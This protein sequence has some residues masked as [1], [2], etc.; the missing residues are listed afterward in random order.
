[1][2]IGFYID[3][4]NLRGVAN[5]TYLYALNNEKILKNKSIIFYNKKNFRNKNKV[6]KKFK[7]KF[8]CI[9]VS[10]FKEIELFKEK[11]DLNFLYTQKSGNKD[12]WISKKIRTIVHAAYPQTLNE[13]HG[14]NFAYVSEW[15]S[16]K[17]SNRKIPFVPYIT[18]S[19]K[20]KSNLRNKL[21][22]KKEYLVFG[23]HGGDSSFD[24]K[25]VQTAVANVAHNRKDIFFLFLNINKF[26][27]HPQVIFLKGTTDEDYKKRFI[28][29]CDAMIY[30]RS[31]GE[32]FGMACAEF[33]V[34]NKDIL[35]YKFNRHRCHKYNSE[36]S[37]YFE[38]S[39]YQSLNKILIN[40]KK[41]RL[42]SK[43]KSKYHKY[44]V[45]KVMRDFEQFFLKQK[46]VLNISIMDYIS[47][48]YN[49]F[50]MG[51][52]YFRHKLY[53]HYFNFFYS[54]F[55]SNRLIKLKNDY[56]N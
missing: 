17:F 12:N 3:E 32:S 36:Q 37:K 48:Y 21:K 11:F 26:F 9:G 47:N 23:C 38:Y 40:Y 51:Y 5:S 35:S 10:S 56:T 42:S 16:H 49:F 52:F 27:H 18:E 46:I 39:S 55:L 43:R 19:K 44:S 54:K 13:I 8:T 2:K 45:K 50:L 34:Q 15:L 14:Y 20:T 22:I 7:K 29:S 25:F 53:N 41:K 4:M 28:N 24:M 1:M 6:I 33:A 30:G 31:L